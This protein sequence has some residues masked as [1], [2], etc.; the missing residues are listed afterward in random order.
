[1]LVNCECSESR[2]EPYKCRKLCSRWRAL[3]NGQMRSPPVGKMQLLPSPRPL[4]QRYPKA[5]KPLVLTPIDPGSAL[6]DI[7][8]DRPRIWEQSCEVS[9]LVH[10]LYELC[11]LIVC[12]CS[13][14]T[15]DVTQHCWVAAGKNGESSRCSLVPVGSVGSRTY[16]LPCS[17]LLNSNQLCA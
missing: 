11:P 14:I 15:R 12:I 5:S 4:A 17:I 3:L 9:N 7:S 1:M 8:T 16:W 6:T 10:F 13:K 2:S